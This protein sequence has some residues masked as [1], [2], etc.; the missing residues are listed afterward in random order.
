MKGRV[1]LLGALALACSD[2][3][4]AELAQELV[5]LQASRVARTSFERMRAE[6]DTSEGEIGALEADL[7]ALRAAFG[8]AQAAAGATDAA[9]QREIERNGVLNQE[10]RDGQQRLQEAAARQAELEKELSIARARAETFRDQAN[11]LAK[12]LRPDD[13]EWAVRLR[14]RSL[15]EFLGEVAA[16]WPGDPVLSE[17]ARSALPADDAEATRVGADLALRIRDRVAEVY[18][19]GGAG[20]S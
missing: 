17:A 9:I 10:I 2:P 13:P 8:E 5:S 7:E 18:G 15:R 19:L 12:E 4:E 11:A 6:V 3:R 14:L 1:A 16:A 20:A